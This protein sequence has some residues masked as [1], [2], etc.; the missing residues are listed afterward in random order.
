MSLQ[1]SYISSSTVLTEV[2]GLYL[3]NLERKLHTQS[4]QVNQN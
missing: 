1:E 4:R 3:G 2:G